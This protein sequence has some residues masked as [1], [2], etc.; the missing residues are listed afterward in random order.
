M[1]LTKADLLKPRQWGNA[2]KVEK[3]E[4]AVFDELVEDV[5]KII[6]IAFTER[7]NTLLCP[8]RLGFF[9]SPDAAQVDAPAVNPNNLL[10]PI[11]Y[12]LMQKLRYTIAAAKKDL[13]SA[14]VSLS[15]AKQAKKKHEDQ[16]F[17][18]QSRARDLADQVTAAQ[19]RVDELRRRVADDSRRQA[20]LAG[21]LN[22]LPIF[23]SGKLL[24]REP[25]AVG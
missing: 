17:K 5:R 1:L 14:E 2:E 7:V 21:Q 11:A 12:T 15:G 22:H 10:Q 19:K 6:P 25:E 9:N 20:E 23:E 13:A 24:T 4:K 16:W 18:T 3:P 8:V